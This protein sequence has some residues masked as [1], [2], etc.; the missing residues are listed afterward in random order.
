MFLTETQLFPAI[1]FISKLRTSHSRSSLLEDS[2]LFLFAILSAMFSPWSDF[3]LIF[4]LYAEQLVQCAC[5]ISMSPC[6]DIFQTNS[7]SE[8]D[9][10]VEKLGRLVALN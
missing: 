9:Q 2:L 10:S 3:T 4:T 8:K 5:A 7:F 6:P 1:L